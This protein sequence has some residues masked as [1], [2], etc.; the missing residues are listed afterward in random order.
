MLACRLIAF[1]ALTI[2]Q[3]SAAAKAPAEP[4]K[5]SDLAA[6][7]LT[8]MTHA[9]G[10]DEPQQAWLRTELESRGKAKVAFDNES[11]ALVKA[12]KQ[13]AESK[14]GFVELQAR[15]LEHKKHDPLDLETLIALVDRHVRPEQRAVGGERVRNRV[16]QSVQEKVDEYNAKTAEQLRESKSLRLSLQASPDKAP[17]EPLKSKP[18][19]AGKTPVVAR[20]DAGARGDKQPPIA[21]DE[22][23]QGAAQGGKAAVQG[24]KPVQAGTL[25]PGGGGAQ[26]GKAVPGAG[27]EAGRP[28]PG[29]RRELPQHGTNPPARPVAVAPARVGEWP[30]LVADAANKYKFSAA[31]RATAEAILKDCQRRADAYRAVH[32]ADEKRLGAMTDARQ[33]S[34]AQAQ[35]EAPMAAIE[36]ELRERLEQI[37]TAEQRAAVNAPPRPRGK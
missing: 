3:Q 26:G 12:L 1:V 11:D 37:P 23:R 10:L 19:M 13:A 5:A 24:G 16:K 31:Q 20:N 17:A 25:V 2:G 22:D 28:L 35:L 18:V 30:R 21:A 7:R 8:A 27:N 33:R 6:R 32:A 14:S 29:G 36:Q 9:Y 4:Q 15:Y 34:A